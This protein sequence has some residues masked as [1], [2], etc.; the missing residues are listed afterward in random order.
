MHAAATA[1]AATLGNVQR[2]S[3][4]QNVRYFKKN[5]HAEIGPS[6]KIAKGRRFRL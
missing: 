2:Y 6:E 3:T 1:V 4:S 5:I